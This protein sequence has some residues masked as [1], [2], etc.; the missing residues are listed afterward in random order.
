MNESKTLATYISDTNYDNIPGSVLDITKKSFLDVLGVILA[1]G[2]LGEGCQPF[3]N[4]AIAERG[5][6]E[7]TIIGFGARVPAC[8]AALANGSMAHALDFDNRFETPSGHPNAAPIPAAL[9]VAESI[10]NVNGKD[11]ITALTLASDITCRL[12]IA[13][14]VDPRE[15]GFYESPILG[16]FGAT[17]AAGKLLNLSPEQILDAFSLT[18]CQYTCSAELVNSPRSVIRGIQYAF[19]AKAGVLSALLARDGVAGGF[20]QPFEGKSG[21]YTMYSQGKYDSYVLTNGLGKIFESANV[22][23]KP[24]PAAGGSQSFIEA[25]LQIIDEY[26]VKPGDIK[27]INV[28]TGPRNSKYCE[29]LE[30]RRNPMTVA[31]AKQSIPFAVAVA[32]AHKRVAL[33]HFTL[34]ALRDPDVLELTSKITH[35][36][37]SVVEPTTGFVRLEVETEHGKM[38]SRKTEFTYG[39]PKNPIS[40]EALIAKF[41]D[42][43]T[44]SVKKISEKNLNK[45]VQ[46]VLHLEDVGNVGEIMK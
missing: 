25:A 22:S 28:V 2:T 9:A 36:E 18:L 41:M 21:L 16:A 15:Y 12:A 3:V 24:W 32:F 29:P 45:V 30:R 11:F 5:K 17:A 27:R 6:K 37:D 1:A 44:H 34:Q 26:N 20:D 33:S 40:Q 19:P 14:R 13:L 42:C 31:D 43:A 4:L 35:E 46:L 39:H 8:M 23:F 7:S 10:G 38:V